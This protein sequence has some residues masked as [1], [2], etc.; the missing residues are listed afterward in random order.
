MIDTLMPHE[1]LREAYF[2]L[3]TLMG[4]M[5][6]GAIQRSPELLRVCRALIEFDAT[7][8]NGWRSVTHPPTETTRVW[9]RVAQEQPKRGVYWHGE[10]GPWRDANDAPFSKATYWRPR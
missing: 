1:L 2:R 3:H 9:L 8:E 4:D 7:R 6:P 10:E 5:S